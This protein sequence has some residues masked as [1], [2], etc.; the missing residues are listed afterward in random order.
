MGGFGFRVEDRLGGLI[1]GFFEVEARVRDEPFV[2]TGG[3]KV[4][5]KLALRN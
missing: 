4:F 5:A 1:Q 3:F 2:S